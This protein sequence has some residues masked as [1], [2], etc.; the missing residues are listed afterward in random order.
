MRVAAGNN[1]TVVTNSD[2]SNMV[3][4]VSG[5]APTNAAQYNIGIT[6]VSDANTN[7]VVDFNN[8]TVSIFTSE[9][10]TLTN[11]AGLESGEGTVVKYLD[12]DVI[13]S[14]TKSITFPSF[15]ASSYN[16]R[17]WTNANSTVFTAITNGVRY[18]LT[19]K[20]KG[21]NLWLVGNAWQ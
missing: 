15:G 18:T 17:L 21:T 19:W 12:M 2:G 11:F 1:I 13:P 7:I 16:V 10:F 3:Y 5:M 8:A 9:T 6:N 4:T 20:A 14:A